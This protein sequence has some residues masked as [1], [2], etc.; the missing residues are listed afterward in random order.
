VAIDLTDELLEA[1]APPPTEPQGEGQAAPEEPE[2][3][4]DLHPRRGKR[5]LTP[6]KARWTRTDNWEDLRD[7]V[8]YVA[9]TIEADRAFEEE[10]AKL[11]GKEKA[12]E[13]GQPAPNPLRDGRATP[14]RWDDSDEDLHGTTPVDIPEFGSSSE[15]PTRPS[16][17]QGEEGQDFVF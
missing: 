1:G 10:Q 12:L 17:E 2:R 4:Q 3:A 13:E 15:W 14:D 16:S 7:P 5:Q 11:K 6:V 9:R 8:G